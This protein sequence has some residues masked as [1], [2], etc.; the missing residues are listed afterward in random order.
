MGMGLHISNHLG[1]AYAVIDVTAL[2]FAITARGERRGCSVG[3]GVIVAVG[4]LVAFEM[5][6]NPITT[7]FYL[8]EG[9][10]L[11]AG[12]WIS[13]AG[14]ILLAETS[15]AQGWGSWEAEERS[16]KV[17]GRIG[18]LASLVGLVATLAGLFV[19]PFYQGRAPDIVTLLAPKRGYQV[20]LGV[21]SLA[22][23]AVGWLVALAAPI[24]GRE[25]AY[26]IGI[27]FGL[28]VW[29][30]CFY[31]LVFGL[32]VEGSPWRVGMLFA[33]TGLLVSSLGLMLRNIARSCVTPTPAAAS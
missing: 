25:R 23:G 14:L 29:L 20:Y 16:A 13:A 1:K 12:T 30:N 9:R 10:E 7:S 8:N 11:V 31:F 5:I 33:G 2:A 26:G 4:L 27:Q 3:G 19:M 15:P 18:L 21:A 24:L 6:A 28:G 32:P 22:V 17:L